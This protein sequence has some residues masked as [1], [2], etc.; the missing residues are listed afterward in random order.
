MKIGLQLAWRIELGGQH[1]VIEGLLFDL[2]EA[3]ERGGHLNYAASATSVSYR[4]AW[5]LMR[6]WEERLK[7][8]LLDLQRGR[9][10]TLTASGRA[11]LSARAQAESAILRGRA[12]VM[13]TTALPSGARPA[14]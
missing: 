14:S 4:H 3:V 6:T 5:G 9:G 13:I 1:Y 10:A 8:P 2:L 12:G 7:L 11:L